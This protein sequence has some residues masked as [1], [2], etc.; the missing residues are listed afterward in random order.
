ME[1]CGVIDR[2]L[3]ENSKIAAFSGLAFNI[4]KFLLWSKEKFSEDLDDEALLN[5]FRKRFEKPLP[6]N[7]IN[8]IFI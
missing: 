4:F 8:M 3:D 1:A 5:L 7:S 6:L 2:Q